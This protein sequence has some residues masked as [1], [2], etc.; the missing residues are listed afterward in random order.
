MNIEEIQYAIRELEESKTTVDNV[1]ELANL[2]I[3]RDNL[4]NKSE[5]QFRDILPAYRKY[6]QIKRKYQL[7]EISDESVVDAVNLLCYELKEFIQTL[8]CGTDLRKE[9]VAIESVLS[10]QYNQFCKSSN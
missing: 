4:I 3:V 7:G 5:D 2:Y 6:C 9:R 10:N 1:A 8:Y